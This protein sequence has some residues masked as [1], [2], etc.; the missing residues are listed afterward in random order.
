MF[1]LNYLEAYIYDFKMFKNID[2]FY[3]NNRPELIRAAT[4]KVI[5]K[6]CKEVALKL[7]EM[8]QSVKP[9]NK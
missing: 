9:E 2:E 7:E 3:T 8:E 5:A 6:R 1:P 4:L